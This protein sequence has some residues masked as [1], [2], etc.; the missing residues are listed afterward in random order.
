VDGR[1]EGGGEGVEGSCGWGVEV[2][3]VEVFRF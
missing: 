1:L 3:G 2:D